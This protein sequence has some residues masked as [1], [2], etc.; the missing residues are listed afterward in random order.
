ML[1]SEAFCSEFMAL[2]CSWEF[3]DYILSDVEMFVC[4]LYARKDSAGINAAMYSLFRIT[5][6][7]EALPLNQ[8]KT[9]HC[10]GKLLDCNM[11]S[12]S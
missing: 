8:V 10:K 2:D 12:L 1:E 7:F 4:A 5:C 3:P 9:P 11:L 6:R